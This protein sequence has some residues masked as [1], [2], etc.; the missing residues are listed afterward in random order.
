MF[1]AGRAGEQ[2][3]R[4]MAVSPS[5]GEVR[6]ASAEQVAGEVFLGDDGLSALPTLAHRVQI[7]QHHVPQD[8]LHGEVGEQPVKHRLRGGFVHLLHCSGERARFIELSIA[9]FDGLVLA[10]RGRLILT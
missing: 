4:P 6:Q 5:P 7:R 10:G 8:R 2:R 1:F 3:F 9:P